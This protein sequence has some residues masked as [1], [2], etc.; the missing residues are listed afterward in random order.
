[1][2]FTTSRR[3][4]DEFSSLDTMMNSTCWPQ[5]EETVMM[6]SLKYGHGDMLVA[7]VDRHSSLT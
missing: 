1:M 4:A 3:T 7:I 6:W 5:E 2:E